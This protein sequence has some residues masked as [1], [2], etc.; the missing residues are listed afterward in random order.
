MKR[1]LVVSV[2]LAWI[3]GL[4]FCFSAVPTSAADSIELTLSHMDPAGSKVD[5]VYHRWAKKMEEESKGRL[6]IRVFP[7]AVLVGAFDTYENVAKGVADIGGSF[8]YNRKGAELT[9]MIS[10]YFAGI[11]NSAIGT[12]ILDEIREKFPAYNKEW[13]DTKEMFDIAIGPACLITKSKPLRTLEDIRGV[14]IRVPV[15]EAAEMLK[16][17]GGIPVGMPMGELLIAMKKGT[18]DGASVQL[19][20]IQSFKLA[21]TAKY[22]TLF[23]LYNPSNY[24]MVMNWDKY[25]KLPK[26]LQKIIDDSRPWVKQQMVEAYDQGD[27]SGIAW[28]KKQGMEF[29]T[30]KRE[31][32]AKWLSVI[33][34]EQDKMAADLDSK[35]Y[36]G[37]EVLKFVRERMDVYIK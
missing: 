1:C 4:F 15:R 22:C 32:R 36:P 16:T 5:Q 29:I 27:Q 37:T 12:R 21:P 7:G 26:D 33:G 13:E 3:I 28:A 23:S 30:L 25:N 17:M 11:P 6:K 34:P 14:Q 20:A 2:S 19:Y 18:V 35:G 9:G 10:M 8:R 31:E 24:F